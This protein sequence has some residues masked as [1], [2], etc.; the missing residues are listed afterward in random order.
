MPERE[1]HCCKT[2][3]RVALET[4]MRVFPVPEAN[5]FVRVFVGYVVPACVCDRAVDH[6]YF[7]VSA[8]VEPHVERCG[9]AIE[10][11]YPYAVSSQVFDRFFRQCEHT[12]HIVVY[13]FNVHAVLGALDERSLEFVPNRAALDYKILHQ[14]KF[15]RRANIVEHARKKV[16][17]ERK[18]FRRRV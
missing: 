3:Y 4:H 11:Q 2:A 14:Y 10:R 1:K 16:V 12:S 18:V 13:Y 6:G 5:F 7:S 15:P 8:I 17:A 9:H